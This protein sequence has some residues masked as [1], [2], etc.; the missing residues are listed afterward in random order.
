MWTLTKYMFI[1]HILYTYVQLDWKCC[2]LAREHI[3]GMLICCLEWLGSMLYFFLCLP[4]LI[5]PQ[6][7]HR[8]LLPGNSPHRLLLSTDCLSVVWEMHRGWNFSRQK[9]IGWRQTKLNEGNVMEWFKFFNFSRLF[10]LVFWHDVVLWCANCT[11]RILETQN[12]KWNCK[13]CCSKSVDSRSLDMFW[14][15]LSKTQVT[16]DMKDPDLI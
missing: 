9:S 2:Q 10:L 4:G 15:K 13:M 6:S 5:N 8:S 16:R 12:S 11:L 7:L 3:E 14:I 1:K